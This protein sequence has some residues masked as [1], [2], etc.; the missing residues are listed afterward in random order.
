MGKA[1][2]T[3]SVIAALNI[4][5]GKNLM[6][7]IATARRFVFRRGLPLNVNEI[8]SPQGGESSDPGA[9]REPDFQDE[10]IRVWNLPLSLGGS[11][12]KKR[13]LDQDEVMA[14]ASSEELDQR[15][16]EGVVR[17]MFGSKWSLDTLREMS[18]REVQLPCKVFIRD[19]DGH[20]Q[21]YD[22][23][24]PKEI[25][26]RPD[27]RVLVRTPWPATK[28]E[29]LP[30][31]RQTVES[32]CYIVKGNTRRGKFN[33]VM[34]TSLG[35]QKLDFRKLTS[36][37]SVAGT[38]GVIVTP[39]MVM[40]API[41]GSGFALIDISS[42]DL[43]QSFL[44]RPE[45]SD[46]EIM[47]NLQAMYWVSSEQFNVETEPRLLDF[48]KQ[49]SSI[50]HIMF[51]QHISPNLL[52]LE[53][54][55]AQM[56]KLNCV[57]P[58]R[59]H[60]P[61]FSNEP[62]TKLDD[63][64]GPISEIG[65]SGA[66][67]QLAPKVQFESI[68]ATPVMNTLRP[69]QELM[70]TGQEII[71]L[72]GEARKQISDPA[73]LAQVKE[74]QKDMPDLE[75]EIIPLGT[76]S[77]L[78]SKY[79]NVSAN[80][81]RVPG[82][83][84]YIIDCGENTL[85]QLRRVYG[86]EGA[87]EVLRDLRAIC[88][89]HLHADHHLGTASVVARWRTVNSPHKLAIV[90]T[91][92]F[93]D[94]LQEYSGVEPLGLENTIQVLLGGPRFVGNTAEVSIHLPTDPNPAS[95]DHKPEDFGLPTFEGCY[96]DH[97]Q[98]AMALVI[99]FP[100]SG[101]KIAYSGDCRPSFAFARLG[102]G[103]HLLIHEC[104][105]EDELRGD[106]VAKK[107]STLSEALAVGQEMKARRILLTHFSQRY[108]KLPALPSGEDGTVESIRRQIRSDERRMKLS[109]GGGVG[110]LPEELVDI[111]KGLKESSSGLDQAVVFAFDHMRVKLGEFKQA[112]AFIPALR[113][114]LTDEERV[115]A[116]KGDGEE[117]E[118]EEGNSSKKESG[119]GNK[120]EKKKEK[121]GKKG[122]Q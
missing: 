1:D 12:S 30:M 101:L 66:T 73:F 94:W 82:H 63:A 10:F 90:A 78:P 68:N 59:F 50:K 8:R 17:D 62:S 95:S 107:H 122:K 84:S 25:H 24:I 92:K 4:H 20:I 118:E 108:P 32:M 110:K 75:T 44:N 15:I 61:T 65:K 99:T 3:S 2:L 53:S 41:E 23:Q 6:H 55:A 93:H 52:S 100:H 43:V 83:G 113:K 86:Y 112:E 104:T 5:G 87:D 70:A 89:S 22:A 27:V 11:P 64:L 14:D 16:R 71:K 28:L 45:W 72:A 51:G 13:K 58:D 91:S 97:C 47:K 31:P 106:A 96:V 88:I 117:E 54:P 76:G 121:K 39:E 9:E 105:F 48:M 98:D 115:E 49:H 33:P 69:V 37:E 79:R 77:A 7:S 34:A 74:L 120:K 114:L 18:L 111:E 38:D 57:D 56:I 40:E 81:I 85:G 60:L 36:G 119:G 46:A 67:L 116:G 80:L 26:H 109:R 19:D 35:V 42:K 103:A 102:K 21:P 29:R